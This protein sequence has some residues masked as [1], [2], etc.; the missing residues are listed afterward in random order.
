LMASVV[1]LT[2]G[3]MIRSLIIG[4][5]VLAVSLWGASA[6]AA[7]FTALAVK[8]GVAMPANVTQITWLKTSPIIWFIVEVVKKNIV[9]A[10]ILFVLAVISFY[11]LWKYFAKNAKKAVTEQA[12]TES[13]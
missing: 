4:T 7:S 11:L 12:V 1:L 9:V 8:S 10:G 13:I 3:D 5:I 6:V 2:N